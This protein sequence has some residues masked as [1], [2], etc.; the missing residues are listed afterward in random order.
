MIGL[1]KRLHAKSIDGYRIYT[2]SIE[3]QL[4]DQRV[5]CVRLAFE[6]KV[7]ERF[8]ENYFKCLAEARLVED[9]NEISIEQRAFHIRNN[10]TGEVFKVENW[11]CE[12][13]EIIKTGVPCVHML[14]CARRIKDMSYVPLFNKRWLK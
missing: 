7:F 14:E 8:I 5:K 11:V 4:L 9:L 6:S 12:C 3:Y 13:D 10:V 1:D 2:E